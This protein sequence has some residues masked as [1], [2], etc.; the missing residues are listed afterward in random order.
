MIR[1]TWVKTN[2]DKIYKYRKTYLDKH[3]ELLQNL[4]DRI[5][6]RD[7]LAPVIFKRDTYTCSICN[8]TSCEL[9]AHH[10]SP[11][12]ED[13]E[14]RFNEQNIITLCKNCHYKTHNNGKWSTIN[15]DITNQLKQL[16][17]A[18]YDI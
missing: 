2:P 16:I 4:E 9:R 17:E 12:A 3:P 1:K 18:K 14:N 6:F 5:K 13:E 8:L 7:Y 10:I 11:W 15:E